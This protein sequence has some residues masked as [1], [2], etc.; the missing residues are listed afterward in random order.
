MTK[1]EIMIFLSD[2]F[3]KTE[4]GKTGTIFRKGSTTLVITP[5]IIT[6]YWRETSDEVFIS[7]QTI[8]SIKSVVRIDYTC[9]NTYGSSE[10]SLTFDFGVN[11]SVEIKVR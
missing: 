5:E 2:V 1:E 9:R 3:D 10:K 11:G 8:F 7:K 6:A 4:Q